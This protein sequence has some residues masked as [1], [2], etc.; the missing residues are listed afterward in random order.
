MGRMRAGSWVVM[1]ARVCKGV[2]LIARTAVTLMNVKAIDIGC[3]GVIALRQ[4]GDLCDH[5]DAV[6]RLVKVYGSL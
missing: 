2:C 1:S 3:T 4:P 6:F 5:Q